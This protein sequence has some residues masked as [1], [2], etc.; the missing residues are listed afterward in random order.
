ML[1]IVA[2]AR[3]CDPL[4]LLDEPLWRTLYHF[5]HLTEQDER[6]ALRARMDRIDLGYMV[7][8][9]FNRPAALDDER[10][11][12]LESIAEYERGAIDE[13][14]DLDELRARGEAMAARIQQAGVLTDA[15]LTQVAS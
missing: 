15:A 7:A 9:A 8:Q 14:E 4:D 6:L 12:A 10:R 2:G 13:Q 3:R 1:T 5:H 11:E